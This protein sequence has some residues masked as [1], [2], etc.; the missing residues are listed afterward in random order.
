[1]QARESTSPLYEGPSSVRRFRLHE[2]DERIERMHK[3]QDMLRF[4]K[5]LDQQ[6]QEKN[7]FKEREAEAR[8]REEAPLIEEELKYAQEQ[9]FRA[10]QKLGHVA[11]PV[12]RVQSKFSSSETTIPSP[13]SEKSTRTKLTIQTMPPPA[14]VPAF[15][16]Q[17][18]PRRTTYQPSYRPFTPSTPEK[19]SS[20]A[21][22]SRDMLMEV[23]ALL[24][25]IRY[26]RMQLRQEREMIAIERQRLSEETERLLTLQR[27]TSYAPSPS[28]HWAQ[29]DA[30]TISPKASPSTQWAPYKST[31]EDYHLKPKTPRRTKTPPTRKQRFF[32]DDDDDNAQDSELEQSLCCESTFIPITDPKKPSISPLSSI[33][34]NEHNR[35]VIKTS[36]KYNWDTEDAVP[37]RKTQKDPD[38]AKLFQVKISKE[39]LMDWIKKTKQKVQDKVAKHQQESKLKKQTFKGT[40]YTLQDAPSVP[41]STIAASA[42]PPAPKRTM[43]MS[44]EERAARRQQQAE[45]AQRRE[46]PQPKKR[47]TTSALDSEDNEDDDDAVR[48]EVFEQAKAMEQLKIAESGFN[49]YALKREDNTN[50][51]MNRYQ[52]TIS[53]STEARG[54]SVGV[55]EAKVSPK[56][57][58]TNNETHED[59]VPPQTK[60]TLSKLLQNIIDNPEEVKFQKIR[61]SNAQIQA[62]IVAVPIAMELLEH[63]GFDRMVLE[64]GEDY[65]VFNAARSSKELLQRTLETFA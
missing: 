29:F 59:L 36:G 41:S 60:A 7:A 43:N 2:P 13:L 5:V 40:G 50:Y 44:E 18:P 4:R 22:P 12:Q 9:H 24:A 27:T 32:Q 61:L 65:L 48:S 15:E 28:H 26:E 55:N 52:A 21:T 51:D 38:P 54:V 33:D 56:K 25:E 39:D 10:Q 34:E 63:A 42:P 16:M 35:K 3:Q 64:D 37:T 11:A 6:V 8:R 57:Q 53:S 49:P 47:I 45:A 30:Y 17:S 19:S 58:T 20:P 14:P 23:Q 46:I 62:K 1:M 31:R